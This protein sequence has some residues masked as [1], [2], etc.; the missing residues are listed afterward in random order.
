LTI[1]RG[2]DAAPD[3]DMQPE[4]RLASVIVAQVTGGIR[5]RRVM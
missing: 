4:R 1:N 2:P 3:G 5:I